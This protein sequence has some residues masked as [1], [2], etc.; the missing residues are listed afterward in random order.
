MKVPFIFLRYIFPNKLHQ[1]KC[2][3]DFGNINKQN[4]PRAALGL[5]ALLPENALQKE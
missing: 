5:F 2:L 4:S 1:K 3:A